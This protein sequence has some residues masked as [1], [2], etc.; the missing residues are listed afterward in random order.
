MNAF[1]DTGY[2]VAFANR[3]D[4]HHG[5]AVSVA[6]MVAAELSALAK[7]AGAE[8]RQKVAHGLSRG[9]EV[10]NIISPGGA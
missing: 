6:E 9:A 1:P 8:R 7:T 5:W 4:R 10:Q 3:N 2:L